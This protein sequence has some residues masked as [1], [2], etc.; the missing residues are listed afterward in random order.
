MDI[1]VLLLPSSWKE[2]HTKQR[3]NKNETKRAIP[4]CFY[5]DANALIAQLKRNC[6]LN[7]VIAQDAFAI[8][9]NQI[10]F[11]ISFLMETED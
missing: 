1:I 10:S 3:R 4:C 8:K 5:H 9:K 6:D 2:T 11:R 7:P